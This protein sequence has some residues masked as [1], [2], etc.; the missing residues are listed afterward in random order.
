MSCRCGER[1]TILA[2]L[3]RAVLA[4]DGRLAARRAQDIGRSL[5]LDA[6]ESAARL[7]KAQRPAVLGTAS[8]IR[9]HKLGT[10]QHPASAGP[11]R[12][13]RPHGR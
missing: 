9:V 11:S 5:G 3:G 4:A 6:L 10:V 12:P 13:D 2:G 7:I 8:R 1:R